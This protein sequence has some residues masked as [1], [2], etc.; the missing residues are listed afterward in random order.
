MRKMLHSV[1]DTGGS[2]EKTPLLPKGGRRGG[3]GREGL[4]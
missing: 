4:L 1:G 3:G 2:E